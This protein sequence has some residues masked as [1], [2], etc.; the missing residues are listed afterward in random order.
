MV[1]IGDDG[2]HLVQE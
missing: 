2:G 1:A